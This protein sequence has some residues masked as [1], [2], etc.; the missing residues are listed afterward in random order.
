MAYGSKG[1]GIIN[2]LKVTTACCFFITAISKYLTD[3]NG[4]K[5]ITALPEILNG[6]NSR[7]VAELLG[8]SP[9][10]IKINQV[11]KIFM[12]RYGAALSKP[13]HAKFKLGQLVRLRIRQNNL[14]A[15][16]YQQQWSTQIYVI[17]RI[18]RVAPT[19]M[20]TIKQK[21]DD[22]LISGRFYC[23]RNWVASGAVSS[24][25]F[26]CKAFMHVCTYVIMFAMCFFLFFLLQRLKPNPVCCRITPCLSAF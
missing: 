10:S 7:P 17:A 26:L 20:Y 8:Q 6:L 23:P 13:A 21:S 24:L 9:N 1:Y 3:T 12:H 16:A 18:S 4:K 14:F 2:Y 5:W 22:Q 19:F 15:K 11:D 25:S